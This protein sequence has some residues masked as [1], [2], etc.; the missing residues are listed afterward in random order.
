MDFLNNIQWFIAQKINTAI[1]TN[2]GKTLTK[3]ELNAI[4]SRDDI[5]LELLLNDNYSFFIS[6]EIKGPIT[7]EILLKTI[8][9][10]YQEPLESDYINVAFNGSEEWK[11]EV[12]DNYDNDISKIKKIDVFTDTCDPD[13]CGLEYDDGKYI[14]HIGPE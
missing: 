2:T 5:T 1:N 7:V 13:F 11:D 12:L 14:V 6:R 3:E 10:F 9:N 8:Y 4:I